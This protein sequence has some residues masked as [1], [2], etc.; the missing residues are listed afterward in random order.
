[1]FAQDDK[2]ESILVS[3]ILR[4]DTQALHSLIK[5]YEPKLL[6]YVRSKV[7][8]EKDCE[9]LVQDILLSFLDALPLF[10]FRSK[11]WTFML[12]IAH[13]EV[14]D[15]WRKKYAKKVIRCVP[16][17]NVLYDRAL[18]SS[19][20]LS[21]DVSVQIQHV[22]RS[23]SPMYRKILILKYEEKLSIKEIAKK[24]RMS[25]KSAESKLYRARIAFQDMYTKLYGEPQFSVLLEKV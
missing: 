9:E 10:A 23:L 20:E 4:G 17:M 2:K 16:L 15:Y 14:M 8:N 6:L 18:Y 13:H 25:V 1:M 11:L 22:Y 12:G 5:T 3:R 24:L 19:E 21:E 7:G